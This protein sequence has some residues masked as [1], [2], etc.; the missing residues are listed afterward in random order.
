MIKTLKILSP[1]K[2]KSVE[3]SDKYTLIHRLNSLPKELQKK[4][5]ILCFSFMWRKYVP[6]SAKVPSWYSYKI[7]VPILTIRTLLLL[8]I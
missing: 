1:L 7:Q 6:L 2:I 4:I 5:Y 3:K 8:S